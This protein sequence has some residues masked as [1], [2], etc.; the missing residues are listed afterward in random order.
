MRCT[1]PAFGNRKQR[2]RAK[3]RAE[4]TEYHRLKHFADRRRPVK[5][6]Q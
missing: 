4:T 2:W 3:R 6:P 5:P 1:E